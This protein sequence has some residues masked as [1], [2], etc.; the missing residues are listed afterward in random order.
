MKFCVLERVKNPRQRFI[1][2]ETFKGVQVTG[3]NWLEECAQLLH[4]RA[5]STRIWQM[6]ISISWGLWVVRGALVPQ[7]VPCCLRSWCCG[8]RDPGVGWSRGFKVHSAANCPCA[9]GRF[10]D[11]L[12]LETGGTEL[13]TPE[14]GQEWE[15]RVRPPASKC[16]QQSPRGSDGLGRCI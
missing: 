6:E 14:S 12:P 2:R 7:C 4:S 15:G 11:L 5:E 8:A 3:V 10:A 9:C 1:L 16:S 13:L